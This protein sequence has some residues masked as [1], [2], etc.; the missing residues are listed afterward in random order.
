MGV[1]TCI[2]VDVLVPLDCLSTCKRLNQI[3][4]FDNF[5]YKQE[6][7]RW[8]LVHIFSPPPPPRH[9]FK[10]WQKKLQQQIG[11]YSVLTR[12]KLSQ[13]RVEC[14]L[15]FFFR[16]WLASFF[17][18]RTKKRKI[19]IGCVKI[20][21][22]WRDNDCYCPQLLWPKLLVLSFLV[23]YVESV[24]NCYARNNVVAYYDAIVIIV[25]L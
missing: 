12:L 9:L 24:V 4:F 1:G 8:R 2:H 5:L 17:S 23:I 16:Q 14:G 25:P 7:S 20:S 10:F 11:F 13:G 18:T 6:I 15:M 22:G 21:L 19:L 3:S